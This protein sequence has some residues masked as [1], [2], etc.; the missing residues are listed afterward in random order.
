M[1]LQMVYRNLHPATTDDEPPLPVWTSDPWF[2]R[3]QVWCLQRKQ[4]LIDSIK[5]GMP[6]GMVSIWFHRANRS[7]V[8]DIMDGKQR[9]TTIVAF[10]NNDF[11]DTEGKFW[12]DWLPADQKD[13]K[14]VLVV[15]QQVTLED[16]ETDE[17]IY[18]L[19]R[20]INTQSKQLSAGQLLNTVRAG[21]MQFVKEVFLDK[22]N[23]D[24]GY[25]EEIRTLRHTWSTLLC[26]DTFAITSNTAHSELTILAGLVVPLLTGK[27]EAITTSF[28]IIS[29]NGLRD[30][31]TDTMK[32][33][34]FKKMNGDNGF[35]SIIK[36]GWEFRQ[37]KKSK[38]GY[39]NFGQITPIIYLVNLYH[40][41]DS[42]AKDL[43]SK[44][45]QFFKLLDEDEDKEFV[46]KTRFRKNRNIETLRQDITFI[47]QTLNA[48]AAD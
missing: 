35:M 31:V 1:T 28:D 24:G 23:E 9:C 27:N 34:F 2:Q 4:K 14:N 37:F 38:R 20:R 45:D 32:E 6:F 15:V 3:D 8:K 16:H 7:D 5:N 13:A 40:Q 36:S 11:R 22:I 26:K 44:M 21:P 18:E 19:F 48:A 33:N 41:Q 17:K 29:A 43:I 42:D 47:Q 25:A 12:S 39:P 46:W 30:E 10:M